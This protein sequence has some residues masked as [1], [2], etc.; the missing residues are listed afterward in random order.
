MLKKL[1]SPPTPLELTET[2]NQLV[3]GLSGLDASQ[4]T[5]LPPDG[6]EA[7]TVQQALSETF[8]SVAEGKALLETAVSDKGGT[9]SK[10]GETATFQELAQGVGTIPQESEPSLPTPQQIYEETRPRDWLPM[11]EPQDNEMYLLFHILKG[12]SALLAFSVTCT[13]EYTVTLGTVKDGRFVEKSSSKHASAA[14]YTAKLYAADYGDFTSDGTAQVMIKVSGQ[15]ITKWTTGNHPQK[16]YTYN[17]PGW[18]VVE[19][20]C[21]L[22]KVSTLQFGN[23]QSPRLRIQYA[24]VKGSTRL[25]GSG[26]LFWNCKELKTILE[27]DMSKF[28]SFP[29]FDGCSSLLV[30][31]EMKVS[32]VVS[33]SSLFSDCTSLLYFP[34]LY[35]QGFRSTYGMFDGCYNLRQAPSYD[36][37]QPQDAAYMFQNC[38]SLEEAP[39]MD[40]SQTTGMQYMFSNCNALKVIP[41]LDISRVTNMGSIFY[42]CYALESLKLS[43]KDGV[44]S[45]QPIDLSAC[46]F[47]REGLVELFKSLPPISSSATITLEGNPGVTDL[48]SADK[49]IAAGKGWTLAL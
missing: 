28:Y 24:A 20:S 29:A 43:A 31:P 47:M 23:Y 41:N 14:V 40:T 19:V 13:G 46:N 1:T 10:Q 39:S 12:S 32:G 48:T 3:E 9:V 22:P 42:N 38:N 21:R 17:H 7:Q 49:A 11:P 36:F 16:P 25:T 45:P 30:C 37:S 6:M 33:A 5:F 27:L 18:N 44:A 35:C 15:D 4:V 2:V 26:F 8:I 34:T